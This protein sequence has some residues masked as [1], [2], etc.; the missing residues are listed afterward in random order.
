MNPQINLIISPAGPDAIAKMLEKQ[1]STIKLSM[2]E[3]VREE[4]SLQ[5]HM[6]TTVCDI[7]T[8]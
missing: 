2:D 6:Q 5:S 4:I 8:D 7:K 3:F 1:L